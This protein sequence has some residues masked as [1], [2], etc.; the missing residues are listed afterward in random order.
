MFINMGFKNFCPFVERHSWFS[1]PAIFYRVAICKRKRN[2]Q[3]E[4]HKVSDQQTDIHF[5][6]MISLETLSN[7]HNFESF[8]QMALRLSF[9]S[10]SSFLKPQLCKM[11]PVQLWG[12]T[13]F[14]S[15]VLDFFNWSS[16]IE[17][18]LS[19]HPGKSHTYCNT[20][21]S[22]V[23]KHMKRVSSLSPPSSSSILETDCRQLE[24]ACEFF[25]LTM[26]CSHDK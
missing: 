21:S 15:D 8:L 12:E 24:I 20:T 26:H 16:S 1:F 22:N 2:N 4:Q 6:S 17:R 18:H 5:K 9:F 13:L 14:C 10:H 25:S 19:R 3:Y 23:T 11:Q 7:A